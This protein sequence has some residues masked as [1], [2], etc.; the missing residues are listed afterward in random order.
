MIESAIE[1]LGGKS[2]EQWN[3]IYKSMGNCWSDWGRCMRRLGG[4]VMLRLTTL[5]SKNV[6][7]ESYW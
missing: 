1:E 5:T 4:F 2:G 6:L 7:R 3:Q